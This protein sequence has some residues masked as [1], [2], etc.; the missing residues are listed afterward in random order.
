M[1]NKIKI[2]LLIT[3]ATTASAG[4]IYLALTIEDRETFNHVAFSEGLDAQS[5]IN[6]RYDSY[7]LVEEQEVEEPKPQ[8]EINKHEDKK[9]EDYLGSIEIPIIEVSDSIYKSEGDYYL[10]HDYNK[11]EYEPGELYLDDRTGTDLFT[12]G[13]LLNGHAMPD[14]TKFGNFKK[15]LD[16]DEQPEIKVWN[17]ATQEVKI[18]KMLFVS[19]IDGGTSGIIMDF[20][21]DELRIQYYKNLYDTA[22]KQWEEPTEGDTFMLLNSCAYIIRDG[23]YVVVAKQEE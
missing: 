3:A 10:S 19:L 2:I 9:T 1:W 21:N 22:I 17:E 11:K 6:T 5:I 20:P 14:G 23:H 7:A 13:A 4:T 8:I 16:I 18:Y 12:N 15:L